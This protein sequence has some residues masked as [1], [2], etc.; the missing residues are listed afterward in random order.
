MHP[1][2][3]TASSSTPFFASKSLLLSGVVLSILVILSDLSTA[4]QLH[5]PPSSSYLCKRMS[6]P[7]YQ[8]TLVGALYLLSRGE[9]LLLFDAVN[10]EDY[11]VYEV[12][13]SAV[14]S[15]QLDIS[16][17]EPVPIEEYWPDFNRGDGDWKRHVKQDYQM[18]YPIYRICPVEQSHHQFVIIDSVP[19][20][21]GHDVG[22]KYFSFLSKN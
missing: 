10:E 3:T 13:P 6:K 8:S 21:D 5:A 11:L 19:K 18:F 17:V 2:M 16:A 15:S 4:G 12:P 9:R 1:M 7:D 20:G 14:K 22:T